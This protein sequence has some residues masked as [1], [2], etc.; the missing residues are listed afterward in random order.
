GLL[1]DLFLE[2]QAG[3]GPRKTIEPAALKLFLRYDWPGNVRELENEVMR[4]AAFSEGDIITEV[5][6]LENAAFLERVRGRQARVESADESSSVSTLEQTE[7]EQ[8]RQALRSAG[9]NRTRAAEMLGI[10]RST[11]YRKIRKYGEKLGES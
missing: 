11:L 7:L 6:V 5:D 1:V 10:D 4:L 2:Q 8:I 3:D 9:G